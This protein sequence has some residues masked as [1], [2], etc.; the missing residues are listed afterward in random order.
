MFVCA[1]KNW[2]YLE[3]LSK[4]LYDAIKLILLTDSAYM[5]YKNWFKVVLIILHEDVRK[6]VIQ[7]NWQ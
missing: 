6:L 1:Y 7:R 3:C 2:D 4:P 5:I